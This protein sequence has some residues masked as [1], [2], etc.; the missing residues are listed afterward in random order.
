MTSHMESIAALLPSLPGHVP[1]RPGGGACRQKRSTGM[2]VALM[3]VATTVGRNCQMVRAAGNRNATPGSYEPGG[4]VEPH[5]VF[6][7]ASPDSLSSGQ[8]WRGI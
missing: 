2:V 7:C 5:R 4:A 8:L 6:L 1:G 3:R